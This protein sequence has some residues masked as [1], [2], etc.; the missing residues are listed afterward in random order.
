MSLVAV[1]RALE[2][3]LDGIS[4]A[5]A[6]AWENLK[7]TP[8]PGTPYQ[9]VNL[10][11]APPLNPEMGGFVQERGFMQVALAYPLE[12]GPG[13]ALARAETIRATFKR[14]TSFT[15]PAN[16]PDGVTLDLDFTTETYSAWEPFIVT[17]TVANTPEIAPALFEDDRYVVPVRVPFYANY[18]PE[19]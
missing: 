7:F 16:E 12:G 19:E 5:L 6:T 10:L 4:P 18:T 2:T 14:G 3:A 17:T 9:R 13:A 11:A 1:R 15:A 8:T